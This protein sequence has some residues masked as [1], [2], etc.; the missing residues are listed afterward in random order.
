MAGGSGQLITE[1]KR[2]KADAGHR[3]NAHLTGLRDDRFVAGI[4]TKRNGQLTG[5]I[6]LSWL[7]AYHYDWKVVAH[8]QG[9]LLLFALF[10]A[11]LLLW[12]SAVYLRSAATLP[13]ATAFLIVL[14]SILRLPKIGTP[15]MA[16]VIVLALSLV[17]LPQSKQA[18]LRA[19]EPRR[20]DEPEAGRSQRV[21][22]GT[23]EQTEARMQTH[24]APLKTRTVAPPEPVAPV[25][26]SPERLRNAEAEI[27]RRVI[28]QEEAVAAVA[29]ALR[30]HGAGI[31]DPDRP[32]G[33]FLFLG[34]TGSGKTELAKALAYFLFADEKAMVRLDMAEF[35]TTDTIAR[36][37]GSPPGYFG[38]EQGG[39]LT[40]PVRQRPQS[41][42]LLD[43]IEKAD[44]NVWPILLSILDDARLT[45][46]ATGQATDFTKAL[47][48]C[49]SNLSEEALRQQIP[50]ELRNRFDEIIRFRALTPDEL[51]A[52]AAIQL[53][54]LADRL[55]ERRD[56]TLELTPAAKAILVREGYDPEMG[57]RPLKR[58]IQQRVE[59]RLGELSAAGELRDGQTVVVDCDGD[60]LSFVVDGRVS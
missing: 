9:D 4:F 19:T 44:Q 48:V 51:W 2:R 10:I 11:W 45:E 37:V 7:L 25:V 28:G 26:I 42:V 22:D 56:I 6:A 33:S 17:R 50:P 49:T 41:V 15:M 32:A 16:A 20:P 54:R 5:A 1:A 18:A 47:I 40:R 35:H 29:H 57:A 38:S 31:S 52:I 34:P 3:A 14:P 60:A 36:L 53:A 23:L 58:V 30:R 46:A 39:Q 12:A 21:P 59:N 8:W 43:E 13:L 55:H 24:F 27:G